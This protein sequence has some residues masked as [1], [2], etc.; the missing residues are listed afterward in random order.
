MGSTDDD[1]LAE[2]DEKPQHAIYTAAY[3]IGKYPVTNTQYWEFV[4]DTGRKPPSGWRK[5]W[6][7]GEVSFPDGRGDHP[8]TFVDWE[9]A[10]AYCRWL[11]EVTGRHYRLPWEAEW[12]KA[13]R[14]LDGAVYPW[15]NELPD[16]RRANYGET[17]GDTTPVGAHP[18][19]ASPYG[20][21]DM[22]GNVWE[23]CGDWYDQD[24]DSAP[25]DS[26]VARGGSW[27][28]D[29]ACLRCASRGFDDPSLK[30]DAVGFRCVADVSSASTTPA[31]DDESPS[32]PRMKEAS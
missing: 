13:A 30:D 9:D 17:V 2:D 1:P 10:A 32:N 14:G 5:A 8:V 22:V 4:A 31:G 18:L 20:C 24:T 28:S 12:E 7:T 21:Q 15:G 19:G 23:W 29:E 16:A 3:Y 26:R 27:C 6:L 25:D 11:G